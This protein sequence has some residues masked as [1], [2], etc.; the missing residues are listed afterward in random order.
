MLPDDRLGAA[1][2]TRKHSLGAPRPDECV[3]TEGA[4]SSSG[5]RTRRRRCLDGAELSQ[6]GAG[7]QRW[8]GLRCD[9]EQARVGVSCGALTGPAAG[10]HAVAHAPS[11]LRRVETYRFQRLLVFGAPPVDDPV[12]LPSTGV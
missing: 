2:L 4:A 3:A 8:C 5:G 7:G 9:R 11:L 6:G 1:A 12:L 10:G